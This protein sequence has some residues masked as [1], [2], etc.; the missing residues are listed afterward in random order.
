VTEPRPA[1]ADELDAFED[2][3]HA[4]FHDDIVASD[5]AVD[6]RTLEAE[7]TLIIQ[8]D[9]EV[10]AT[11]ATL[12]RTMSVPGGDAIPIGAVSAV[13]VR[14][15][16]TRRGHLGALMRRQLDDIHAAG[17]AVAALWA[18]EGAIYG[19]YGYGPATQRITYELSPA[20]AAFRSDVP[21]P[22]ERARLAD[23]AGALPD[24]TVAYEAAMPTRPGLMGRDE[25]WWERVVYDPEHRRDGTGARRAVVQPGPDGRAAGYVLYAVTDG[26]DEQ[27]PSGVL[28]VRELIASTPEAHLGLWRFLLSIDLMRTVSFPRAPDHE[29]LT[30]ALRSTDVLTRRFHAHGL[31]VRLVDARAALAAR[32]YSAPL[33]VVLEIEDAFCPWNAGRLRLTGGGCEPTEDA[34]DLV[35]GAEALASAYLG[36]TP[37]TALAGAGR[38]RELTPGS[39]HAASAAFGGFPEPYC[40]DHF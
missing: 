40:P 13:G 33:D 18:S 14:P 16:H 23:P 37:L 11:A 20:R 29:P 28:R 25:R 9:G 8:E 1:A 5:L 22:A 15:G 3:A 2:A 19:R 26:W 7:R 39:L 4:A 32:A 34:P 31:W 35:V 12:T 30:Y 10:V 6:R 17:E 38:V 36:S 21:L 27:G 24:L